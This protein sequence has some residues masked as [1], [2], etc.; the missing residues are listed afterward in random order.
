MAEA[1]VELP[2]LRARQHLVCLDHLTEALFR[3]GRIGDVGMEL[4]GETPE[5]ALDVVGARVAADAE[6]LVVVA[7]GAQLSSYTS[8]TKRDSS[9]AAPRTERIAFS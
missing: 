1:V 9:C 7:L 4:A 6:K 5:R 3:V 8:S 2:P